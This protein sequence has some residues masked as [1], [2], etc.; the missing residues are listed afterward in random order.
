MEVLAGDPDDQFLPRGDERR[1]PL[2]PEPV[3]PDAQPDYDPQQRAG[4]D[5]DRGVAEELSQA[6]LVDPAVSDEQ[7]VQQPVDDDRLLAGRAPDTGG[8]VHDDGAEDEADG[9][10]GRLDALQP[11]DDGGER[12]HQRAVRA[13][14]AAC[15]CQPAHAEPVQHNGI[16]DHF[17]RLGNRPGDEGDDEVRVLKQRHGPAVRSTAGASSF[18]RRSASSRSRAHRR[19]RAH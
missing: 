2:E 11:A 18:S 8:V 5:L 16:D 15:G 3:P 4:D 14:H 19:A 7:V 13:R 9:K 17:A 12:H 6:L 10:E 1:V